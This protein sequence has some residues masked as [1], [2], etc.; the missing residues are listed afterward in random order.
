M[1]AA[2]SRHWHSLRLACFY[3]G[4]NEGRGPVTV[5]SAQPFLMLSLL[6]GPSLGC[7][8]GCFTAAQAAA[9]TVYWEP[10]LKVSDEAQ[11]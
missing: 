9:A 4:S 3:F 10:T 1:R 11:E 2:G 6:V 8:V 7:C 5:P